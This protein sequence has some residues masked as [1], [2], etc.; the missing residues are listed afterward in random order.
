MEV[1]R[2]PSAVRVLAGAE[3]VLG[4]VPAGSD[5][6][7]ETLVHLVESSIY[8]YVPMHW[9]S[10]VSPVVGGAAVYEDR[11]KYLEDRKLG[12]ERKGRSW[13]LGTKWRLL[14]KTGRAE[15]G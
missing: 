10:R 14:A 2:Q 4:V 15:D 8:C 12:S 13:V 5:K 6:Q 11:R 9:Y 7:A 1:G 3:A